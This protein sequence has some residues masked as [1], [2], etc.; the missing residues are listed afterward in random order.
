[1]SRFILFVLAVFAAF[2]FSTVAGVPAI[3]SAEA[4]A[5]VEA[6]GVPAIAPGAT[7]GATAGTAPRSAPGGAPV[8]LR[9]GVGTRPFRIPP[10]QGFA[11][12]PR[13]ATITINYLAVGTTNRYG[14]VAGA[15][16]AEAQAAISYAIAIWAGAIT[17]SV[18]IKV[19]ACWSSL[20]SGVLG[21][22]GADSY[23]IAFSGAPYSTTWYPS[24]LAN[25]LSRT[26]L[27]DGDL[28]DDDEDG[29]D[30]DADIDM[31]FNST[32]ASW[33]YG[34]D[35]N[36]GMSKWDLVSV[37]LHEV[38]HGLGFSGSMTVSGGLGRW[39][40]GSAYPF[41]YDQ[42]AQN[43][44]GSSLLDTTLFPNPS[45]AL[46]EQLL[47]DNIF[48]SGAYANAGNGGTPAKLYCPTSWE[49]GSSYSHLDDI[50]NGTLNAL[51]TPSL[52]NGEAAHQAGP[53]G[54]GILYDLGWL[55]S[56]SAPSGVSASDGLYSDKVRIAWNGVS[57]ATSY[58]VWRNTT[59]QAD[60]AAA[61]I[62]GLATT[63]YDDTNAS[64]GVVYY[65]WVTASNTTSSS[66]F[67]DPDTGYRSAAL[68]PPA[69]PTGVWA[70]DGAYSNQV[71]LFWV[72]PSNAT[73]YEIWRHTADQ[74]ASASRIG[75]SATTNYTDAPPT[76]DVVYYYWVKG[77]NSA[78][79]GSFSASESGYRA[80]TVAVPAAP[81]GL[82]ASD[83][84]LGGSVGIRWSAT[85]R[86]AYYQLLRST[87][88]DSGTATTLASNLVTTNYDDASG[89]AGTIYYYWVRAV[90]EAGA[91][92]L[93]ASDSGYA[94]LATPTGVSASDG[95]YRDKIRITWSAVSGATRYEVWRNSSN[96]SG[97]ATMIS[98]NTT[99]TTFD[100]TNTARSVR[101][102][103]W[104]KAQNALAS[105]SFSDPDSGY[106]GGLA[107]G[108]DSDALS[109]L[110][111]FDN[112]TGYWYIRSVSGTL[113]AW[114]VPW[115]WPGADPVSGD[116]D[117]DG[118][119]DLAVFDQNT[120]NWYIRTVS[121]TTIAWAI[122]WGWPG[123]DPVSGDY[124][125]DGINDLA[126]FDSNTGYWYI[127]SVSGTTIAWAIEWGWPGA[128][129]VPGA[130]W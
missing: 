105:S 81:A 116:Y 8:V 32:F 69:A 15:W 124:D 83:G 11:L 49:S 73:G 30:A 24:A 111:V 106:R 64:A 45:L 34:T 29:L 58:T 51:M 100:D 38:C 102:N 93:S 23:H 50:F 79:A 4:L 25:A 67:S 74:S 97:S 70:T 85:A 84:T 94:S 99:T 92:S 71:R 5:K 123:A 54:M 56:L 107:G 75:T 40:G 108:Y 59:N 122:A 118:L 22:A 12:R 128:N 62:A 37:V 76:A 60:T 109:D 1:M 7:A 80:G 55:G 63:N 53:V 101:L 27:N 16:T 66:G 103:Y 43:G 31:A 87:T 110:A 52:A 119:S 125:G 57:G 33:Y 35:G 68:Q 6:P 2:S 3:L 126:V 47:S 72:A 91:G 129:P 120:G 46:R 65:F 130:A 13:S 98:S 115:G 42:F 19:N 28:Y 36:P 44:S 39:G 112:N 117:G 78:G 113:I 21:H 61:L 89:T 90:N 95:S 9:A 26:D 127:R 20:G 48:F 121:G 88:D 114:A 82:Q 17:S 10:P 104:V 86:A 77:T 96:S 41:I 18:P 14:D